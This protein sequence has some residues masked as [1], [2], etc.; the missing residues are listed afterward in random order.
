MDKYDDNWTLEGKSLRNRHSPGLVATN[1][2][3]S[4]AATDKARSKEFVEALWNT[5]VPS[6]SLFRYYDGLLYMMSLLHCSGQFQ[7]LEPQQ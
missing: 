4:L 7:I 2:A 5:K 3:A 1:G 6:D